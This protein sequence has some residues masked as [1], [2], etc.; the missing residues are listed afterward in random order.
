MGFMGNCGLRVSMMRRQL[1][2]WAKDGAS[3]YGSTLMGFLYGLV[4]GGIAWGLVALAVGGSIYLLQPRGL[5][6]SID[7]VAIGMVAGTLP[8]LVA[9]GYA[10]G[11]IQM[12]KLETPH[13]RRWATG[14]AIAGGV[15]TPI[16]LWIATRSGAEAILN[17]SDTLQVAYWLALVVLWSMAQVLSVRLPFVTALRFGFG[18]A[19][20]P[21]AASS[22]C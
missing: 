16:W 11:W 17:L 9:F 6:L 2:K 19:V 5:L 8:G 15:I 3:A 7:P 13:L 22:I 12:P 18:N 4:S 14:S 1:L 21:S 20:Q 10:F